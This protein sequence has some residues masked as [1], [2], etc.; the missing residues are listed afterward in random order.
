M[1][2][3]E[4]PITLHRWT[5]SAGEEW[6][7]GVYDHGPM[8][9]LCQRVEGTLAGILENVDRGYMRFVGVDSV[10]EL[11]FQLTTLGNAA[12]EEMIGDV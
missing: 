6:A 1:N 5:T 8:C 4:G 3:E 11:S 12:A 2:P 10:G 7:C 9:R